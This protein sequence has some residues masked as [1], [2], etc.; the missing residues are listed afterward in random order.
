MTTEVIEQR[1]TGRMRISPNYHNFGLGLI[2]V[3]EKEVSVTSFYENATIK[4][5]FQ[6]HLA[7]IPASVKDVK[8]MLCKAGFKEHCPKL[9]TLLNTT[10]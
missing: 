7:W 9:G 10:A 2:P 8:N 4:W 1:D 6:N 5:N 3:L